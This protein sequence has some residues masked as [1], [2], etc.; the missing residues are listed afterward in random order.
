[1]GEQETG[2]SNVGLL[3]SRF[4]EREAPAEPVL[5]PGKQLSRSFALPP[6]AP[7]AARRSFCL[8]EEF[9]PVARIGGWQSK[10]ECA[11]S[12]MMGRLVILP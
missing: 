1:M 11:A 3:K 2:T 8:T 5:V 6:H 7:C 10:L 9:R 4:W 12:E